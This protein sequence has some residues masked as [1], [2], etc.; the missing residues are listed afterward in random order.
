[1]RAPT[2]MQLCTL[3]CTRVCVKDTRCI[4][5][6]RR[7]TACT[8][9]TL[10]KLIFASLTLNC[11]FFSP[12]SVNFCPAHRSLLSPSSFSTFFMLL[13]TSHGISDLA[14]CPAASVYTGQP[15]FFF[16]VV[17]ATCASP[18]RIAVLCPRSLVVFLSPHHSSLFFSILRRRRRLPSCAASPVRV[19][20]CVC[21]TFFFSRG[22]W[23]PVSAAQASH[24]WCCVAAGARACGVSA[25]GVRADVTRVLPCAA[26]PSFS[27]SS[28]PRSS[29]T[30]CTE[31]QLF[32]CIYF[33]CVLCVALPLLLSSHWVY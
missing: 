16:F 26:S 30:A 1:M 2:L 32:I 3:A 10:Y 17:A 22:A 6:W 28:S 23:P 9:N 7:A 11:L 13:A 19:R 5:T 25:V 33:Q 20:L 8:L 31:A 12:F 18:P 4:L 29:H 21:L 24:G 27:S 14:S 15:L